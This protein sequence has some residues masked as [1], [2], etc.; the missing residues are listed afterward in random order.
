MKLY[1]RKCKNP[2][3]GKWFDATRN[4]TYC[5]PQCRIPTYKV[6]KKPKPIKK[7]TINEVVKQAKKLDMSYGQYVA[8]QYE[9]ERKIK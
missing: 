2:D 4:Q 9:S 8:M 1:K 7:C 3:C 6:K 5:C